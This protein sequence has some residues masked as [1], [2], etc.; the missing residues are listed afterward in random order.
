[1]CLYA[2][3]FVLFCYI[4]DFKSLLELVLYVCYIST[5]NKIL[6]WIEYKKLN[7]DILFL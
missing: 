2:W 7:L 3:L 4:V 6:N 5:L 1:M